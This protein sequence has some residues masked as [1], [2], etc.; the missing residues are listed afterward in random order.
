MNGHDDIFDDPKYDPNKLYDE[1]GNEIEQDEEEKYPDLS[2]PM[3]NYDPQDEL[4]RVTNRESFEQT[5]NIIN[6]ET[7]EPE[8]WDLIDSDNGGLCG[9]DEEEQE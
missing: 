6:N 7:S 4:D 8:D 5:Q 1:D 9:V 2:N 3:I